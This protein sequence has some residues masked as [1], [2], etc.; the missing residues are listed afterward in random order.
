[1]SDQVVQGEVGVQG[2]DAG[3]SASV[4]AVAQAVLR[5][6]DAVQ[7]ATAGGEYSPWILGAYFVSDGFDLL[8]MLEA[9]GKTMKNLRAA[10]RVAFSISKNDA[11]FDFVQGAGEAV[12]LPEEEAAGVVARLTQKMPWY[13]LYTPCLPVRIRA[14]ELFVTSVSRGWIP[15]KRL[16]LG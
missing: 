13:K 3:M 9:A 16:V 4:E 2:T 14:R 15:A 5:G 1:M 7:L 8:L 10:Q 6:H 12:S 11:M